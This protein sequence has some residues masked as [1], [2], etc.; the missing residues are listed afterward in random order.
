M[1]FQK[2]GTKMNYEEFYE[3]D[4]ASEDSLAN[5]EP[6]GAPEGIRPDLRRRPLSP[7]AMKR[8]LRVLEKELQEIRAKCS[9][10][11]EDLKEL[12]LAKEKLAETEKKLEEAQEQRKY[13]LAE[14]ENYKKRALRERSELLRY[15]GEKVL[16]DLLEVADNFERAVSHAEGASK[17][18]LLE[19]LVMI[20]NGLLKVLEKNE[21]KAMNCEGEKFDPN[22]HEA[23]TMC[24][25]P[26]K[27]DG[28]V[29]AV[30]QQGYFFKDHLLRPAKVVV[31]K[32]PE[33]KAPETE[34]IKGE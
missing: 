17:E 8:R 33:E 10:Y 18:S 34:E 4:I 22:V 13:D 21:V 11:E 6:T 19:G 29:L 24:P 9:K 16:R 27:E 26:G 1:F 5:S 15:N 25:A 14:A 2:Q 32:N 7:K 3:D 23:L 28:T 12:P 31:V 30:N 20:K